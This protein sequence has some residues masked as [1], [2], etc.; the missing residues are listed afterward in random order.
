MKL[1][2]PHVATLSVILI[3]GVI[4]LSML[5]GVWQTESSKV[6]AT[7]TTGEFAGEYNPADIRGS[8]TFGDIETAFGVPVRL[9][10]EAYGFAGQENP[11]EIQIKIFEDVYGEFD[12]KEIGTDSVRLFVSLYLERPYV[13]EETTGLPIRALELLLQE[14]KIDAEEAAAMKSELGINISGLTDQDLETLSVGSPE[15]EKE[16][17][18]LT[19]KT[20][21][22]DLLDWGLSQE[23]IEEVIGM[24]MGPPTQALRDFF[25]EQGLEFSSAK[26]ALQKRLDQ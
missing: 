6:P 5:M 8:Y 22:R 19:G 15:E 4:F 26:D 7:Y 24:E 11:E 3:F 25:M 9:L 23:E 18:S 21:F 20:T 1:R 2:S 12:G 13:Q 10:S 17:A 14:G 16:E